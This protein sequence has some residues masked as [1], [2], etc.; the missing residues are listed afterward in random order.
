MKTLS[1]LFLLIVLVFGFSCSDHSLPLTG[2]KLNNNPS[3][4][5]IVTNPYPLFSFYNAKGG[6]G[7]RTYEMQIDT[8]HLFDSD[9]LIEYKNVP[10]YNR[11]ISDSYDITGVLHE[12]TRKPFTKKGRYFWRVRAVDEEGTVGPWVISRF[13][14]DPEADNSFM[15][16]TRIPVED[17]Q[18]SSGYNKKNII[19][20]DDPGQETFW[21]STPPGDPHQWVVFDFGRTREVARIWMLS[22]PDGPG[23]WLKDFVWQ[24]SNDGKNWKDIADTNIKDNDTFRNILDFMPVSAR[25]VRLY[26]ESWHGYAAQLNVV[27]LYSPGRP[28]V[29]HAPDQDY[30]LLVGDQM[31]G[32][33]FTELAEF[34]EGLDFGLKTLTVPHYEV[35]MD[36]VNSL[37]KKPVA[38]ILSG[39]NANYPN[40]P[41]F[42]YNGVY[43]LIRKSDIPILG[44]CCGHQQL[45][46][47]YGYTYAHAEGWA[48]I[49]ALETPENRTKINITKEDPIFKGIVS[50]FV[51]VEIHSWAVAYLDDK[52]DV[53]ADSGYIQAIKSKDRMIYGEQ[54]HAEV[55]VD[56]NQGTPFLVNFLEMAKNSR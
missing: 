10:E 14:F 31:N 9:D 55:K 51:A 30:V 32:Y 52:Y 2:P 49:S 18:V 27:T 12:K 13:F 4:D 11:Y 24:I 36:M 25:Y 45:A 19:D 26:I 47:A 34:V 21:Q 23:G 54:F 29:P 35:S 33:T 50:P 28:P 43:E 3:F 38:I 42:E 8:T 17:I 53:I 40:L 6:K 39:N 5:V 37:A 16:M 56:Y 1:Y 48:D 41:M 46:M 22:N 20:L 44:I 7:K 15:N